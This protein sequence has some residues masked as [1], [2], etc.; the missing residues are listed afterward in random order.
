MLKTVLLLNS[1]PYAV[2]MFESFVEDKKDS[3]THAYIFPSSTKNTSTLDQIKF[4]VSLYGFFGSVKK[5]TQL[6]LRK[7]KAKK[8]SSLEELLHANDIDYSNFDSPKDSDFISGFKAL[9]PDVAFAALPHILPASVINVPKLGIFNKH[10]SILPHYG[11]VYPIF[12]QMLNQEH[13]MG[14]TVHQMNEKIDEGSILHQKKI[15]LDLKNS[16]DSNYEFI[17]GK[18]SEVLS[19]AF[20]LLES[21]DYELQHKTGG[22]YYSFPKKKDIVEF[23]KKGLSII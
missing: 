2:A 10:S 12:W 5:F 8:Y 13:E 22:S 1:N 9:H 3:I 21:K 11:G 23:K 7:L 20:D 17:I 6:I 16:F 14:I 4:L 15:P 18:T 19:E